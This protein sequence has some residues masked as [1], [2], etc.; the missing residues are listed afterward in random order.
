MVFDL[1]VLGYEEMFVVGD[2]VVL[3]D[4]KGVCVLG[5]VL[6]VN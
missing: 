3:I 2:L 4:V 1:S 5:V 6:V